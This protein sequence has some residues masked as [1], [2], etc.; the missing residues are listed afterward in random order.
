M[1][2]VHAWSEFFSSVVTVYSHRGVSLEVGGMGLVE[3]G[4]ICIYMT[5]TYMYMYTSMDYRRPLM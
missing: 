1:L 3:G 2:E 5:I 4:D